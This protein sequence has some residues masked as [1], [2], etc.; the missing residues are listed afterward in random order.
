MNPEWTGTC[1]RCGAKSNMHT[2]SMF[3]QDLVCMDCSDK[4]REHPLF[5]EAEQADAHEVLNGNWNF[6]GIGLPEDL[7]PTKE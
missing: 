7:L 5:K 4:E 6:P 2:M 3:N 1:Q